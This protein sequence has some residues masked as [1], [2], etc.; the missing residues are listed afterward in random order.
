MRI[1]CSVTHSGEFFFV[2]RK[3]KK[4]VAEASMLGCVT[5]N[6]YSQIYDEA[7]DVGFKILSPKTGNAPIFYLVETKKV[8]GEIVSWEFAPS[9]DSIKKFPQLQGYCVSILN[10]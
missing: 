6:M 5:G 9:N 8:N 3:N 10:D 4:M 1:I 2:D 7:C